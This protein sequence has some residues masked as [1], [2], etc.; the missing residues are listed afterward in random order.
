MHKSWTKA[1]SI[2]IPHFILFTGYACDDWASADSV[3]ICYPAGYGLGPGTLQKN[4]ECNPQVSTFP[5]KAEQVQAVECEST[6]GEFLSIFI[7]L[8][9][10]LQLYNLQL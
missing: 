8:I 2:C 5:D 4:R 3:D 10:L 9:S 1:N 7:K 6:I